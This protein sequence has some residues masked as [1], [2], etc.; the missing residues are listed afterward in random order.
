MTSK[1][2]HIAFVML[3]GLVVQIGIPVVAAKNNRNQELSRYTTTILGD[4]SEDKR[5]YP[6]YGWVDSDYWDQLVAMEYENYLAGRYVDWCFGELSPGWGYSPHPPRPPKP[7]VQDPNPGDGFGPGDWGRINDTDI[8]D[9]NGSLI[10]IITHDPPRQYGMQ[11]PLYAFVVRPKYVFINWSSGDRTELPFGN[12]YTVVYHGSTG[13]RY[14]DDDA[15]KLKPQVTVVVNHPYYDTSAVEDTKVREITINATHRLV[16]RMHV[17]S[18]YVAIAVTPKYFRSNVFGS[19]DHILSHDVP[20]ITV[21]LEVDTGYI[22]D[23]NATIA[24]ISLVEVEEDIP[25]KRVYEFPTILTEAISPVVEYA[26]NAPMP[27][28]SNRTLEFFHWHSVVTETVPVTLMGGAYDILGRPEPVIDHAE[29]RLKISVLVLSEKT[30]DLSKEIYNPW[31]NL[32]LTSYTLN[33]EYDFLKNLLMYVVFVLVVAIF[34]VGLIASGRAAA[35]SWKGAIIVLVATTVIAG[36][37][38]YFGTA[39]VGGEI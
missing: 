25:K 36:I 26:E 37:V 24:G 11:D 20:T 30:V 2:W 31:P 6:G 5:F 14:S 3:L 17:I 12:S 7:P 23:L 9:G 33:F 29:L 35:K 32:I 13:D 34:I 38:Y 27:I 18:F 8:G 10:D 16:V 4:D 39:F 21:R 1:Y 15:Y 22:Q 19:Y 28:L